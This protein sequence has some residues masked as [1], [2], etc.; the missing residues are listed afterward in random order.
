MTHRKQHPLVQRSEASCHACPAAPSLPPLER[1]CV[2]QERADKDDAEPTTKQFAVA[3]SCALHGM[4]QQ[5]AALEAASANG[6]GPAL[7]LVGR[8]ILGGLRDMHAGGFAHLDVKTAK[9]VEEGDP[10][11]A[12]LMDLWQRRAHRCGNWRLPATPSHH[13]NAHPAQ[14]RLPIDSMLKVQIPQVLS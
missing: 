5:R 1:S 4:T 13:R 12:A 9:T 3:L 11:N 2:L 10:G 8:C 14:P 7:K 6:V